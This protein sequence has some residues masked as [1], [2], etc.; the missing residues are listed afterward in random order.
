LDDHQ[1]PLKSRGEND[2]ILVSAEAA[3]LMQKPEYAICSDAVR[4][5]TTAAYFLNAFKIDAENFSLNH[6]LYDFSGQDVLRVIKSLDDAYKSV[7]L[8]GHNHAFTSIV[9]MLGSE[10]IDNV[11]TCGFVAIAFKTDSWEKI[12]KGKTIKTI[13]PSQLK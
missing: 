1:R 6:S 12:T 4:A 5:K 3:Q 2:A 10:Y 11:P 7:I 8:F 13:F 9:N